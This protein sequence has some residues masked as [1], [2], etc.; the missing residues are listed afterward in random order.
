[1]RFISPKSSLKEES[2]FCEGEFLVLGPSHIGPGTRLGFN[3]IV[4]YPRKSKFQALKPTPRFVDLLDSLSEGSKIGEGCVLRSG[5]TIYEGAILGDNVSTGHN[6]LIREDSSVGEGTILGTGTQLDGRVSIG[7]NCSIQSLVYLPGLTE[8]GSNV[9]LGPNVIVTNDRYPPSRRLVG[10]K[11]GNEC[12][13]GA[14]STLMA[15]IT[16]GDGSVIA[17]GSIVTKDVPRGVVVKGVPATFHCTREQYEEKKRI[18]E[19]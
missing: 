18:Y 9:F 2:C 19:L 8:V 13:V 16:L 3:V 12:I 10:V 4:G 5:T 15:S 11:I 6:V 1:M 17:A 7:E 14:N